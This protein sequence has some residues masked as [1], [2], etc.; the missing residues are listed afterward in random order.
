[1]AKNWGMDLEG[2]TPTFGVLLP[3][4]N[5]GVEVASFEAGDDPKGNLVT[6]TMKVV[7]GES[8]GGVVRERLWVVDDTFKGSDKHAA[9]LKDRWFNLLV[10]CK[11]KPKDFGDMREVAKALVGRR[12]GVT[13]KH[14]TDEA[15]G[16]TYAN[17]NAYMPYEAVATEA[18]S[19]K[20]T[21][22]VI[23]ETKVDRDDDGTVDLADIA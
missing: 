14:T 8:A 23:E 11:I 6:F 19:L 1:M 13:V 5:H 20:V 18:P 16:R 9:V 21:E 7:A 2:H 10:S 15:K 12:L 17:I 4:G 3:E 22:A